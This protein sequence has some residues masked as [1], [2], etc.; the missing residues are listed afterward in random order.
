MPGNRAHNETRGDH[1]AIKKRLLASFLIVGAISATMILG[2][3]AFWTTEEFRST[4]TA[5]S[6][7]ADIQVA[8]NGQ[9]ICHTGANL[10]QCSIQATIERDIY[11]GWSKSDRLEIENVGDVPLN[12]ILKNQGFNGFGPLADALL[13]NTGRCAGIEQPLTNATFTNGLVLGTIQPGQKLQCQLTLWLPNTL[14][15]QD[16]LQEKT[17]TW[18]TVIYGQQPAP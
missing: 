18:T 8:I 2:A 1:T 16:H 11:P 15:N 10:A 4:V 3:S 14:E 13:L 12:I 17:I 6:G 5:N 7:S 9:D